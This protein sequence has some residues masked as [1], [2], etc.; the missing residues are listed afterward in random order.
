MHPFPTIY[1]FC[2][3]KYQVIATVPFLD[4][5]QAKPD[6]FIAICQVCDDLLKALQLIFSCFMVQRKTNFDKFF[7]PYAIDWP[8]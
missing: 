2:N 7:P 8:Q 6:E 3:L 4:N 1:M 5:G